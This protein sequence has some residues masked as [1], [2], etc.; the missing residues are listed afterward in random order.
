MSG[1]AKASKAIYIT[2]SDEIVVV[3]VNK[4]EYSVD[5]FL[6]LPTDVLGT[7]Y[8]AI[9]YYPPTEYCELL[10][11]GVYDNTVL[12]ITLGS[13]L[14]SNTVQWNGNSYTSGNN[15]TETLQRFDTL[16]I[17]S[18][19]DLSGTRVVGDKNI[20][21]FSGNKKTKIGTG[22][23]RDHL[24]EMWMSVD[25]WG[26]TFVT[27]P[28]SERT[29]GD[30]FKFMASEAGTLV[31]LS[32]DCSDSFTITPAGNVTTKTI[33][34]TSYCLVES[35]KPIMVVQFV[36]SQVTKTE[37]SDPSMMMI[38]SVLQFGADYTFATPKYSQGSYENFFMF[39]LKGTD[40]SDLLLNNNAIST[41]NY[42]QI[43]NTGYVAG[44]FN[45][46]E[47]T[48]TVKHRQAISTFGGYIYGKATYETYAFPTGMR[49]AP[50]VRLYFV[51]E[52]FH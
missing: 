47:G 36:Q 14:G 31:T 44:Y 16:Q 38:P 6:A 7:T 45:V 22:G 24:V 21:F 46:S 32:G 1:T 26:K 40:T 2:A 5:G 9:T 19:F 27:V 39:T 50:S 49:L 42:K 13:L 51:L 4:E 23:S 35:D 8:Y 12:T 18:T 10:V 48:H 3:G 41:T 52:Y 25:Y 15:I 17:Q 30:V 43:G 29:I 33:S 20:V 37:P 34:S 11:V 28:I